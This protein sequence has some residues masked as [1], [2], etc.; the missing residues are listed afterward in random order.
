MRTRNAATIAISW[1]LMV[2][3]GDVSLLKAE[4]TASFTGVSFFARVGEEGYPIFEV[5][6]GTGTIKNKEGKV[7]SQGTLSS[8]HGFIILCAAKGVSF[9]FEPEAAKVTDK[10]WEDQRES[11]FAKLSLERGRKWTVQDDEFR[12]LMEVTSLDSP[13]TISVLIPE[14]IVRASV[15]TLPQGTLTLFGYRIRAAKDGATVKFLH[16][17][18]TERAHCEVAKLKEEIRDPNK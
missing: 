14:S 8:D 15:I 7:I 16:G 4:I 9:E 3:A 1:P 17:K 13:P 10:R 11:T 5:T 6:G 2:L 18:I 12:F